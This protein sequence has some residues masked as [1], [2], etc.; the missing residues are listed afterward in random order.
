M[1]VI[2][3]CE[4][5]D[6]SST[7]GWSPGIGVFIPVMKWFK[8]FLALSTC[9]SSRFTMFEESRSD[10]NEPLRIDSTYFTHILFCRL[11][12]LMVNHP[13]RSLS[14]ERRT[15]MNKDLL[16]VSDSPVAFSGVFLAAME[17]EPSSNGL[18]DLAEVFAFHVGSS[19]SDWEFKSLHDHHKLFSDVLSSLYGTSLDEVFIAP[20]ILVAVLFPSFVDCQ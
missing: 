6:S 12:Q 16:V 1:R 4:S 20:C 5:I 18:S 14:E 7:A 9:N 3:I 2:K 8:L 11:D 19:R 15:R 13:L 17:E 10:F